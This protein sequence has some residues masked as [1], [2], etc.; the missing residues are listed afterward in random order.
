VAGKQDELIK[1]VNKMT[2]QEIIDKFEL[3]VDDAT[4]LSDAEELDLF[5]KVYQKVCSDRPWQGLRKTATGTLSTTNPYVSLPTDF[6]YFADNNTYADNQMA[7]DDNMTP[8]V[9]YVIKNGSYCPYQI[10]NIANRRKYVNTDGYCYADIPNSR[11]YFT[12]Q[13]GTAY[14]Y[15]FDYICFPATLTVA[16]TPSLIPARFHDIFVHLMAVD[17]AIIQQFPKAESY[18]AENQSRA[19]DIL[20]DLAY[21]NSQLNT[22]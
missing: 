6:G 9:V 5:N 12:L 15:E 8:N 7:I 18:A 17:H 22:Q 2:V 20:A 21:Y 19:N 16:D 11:L 13:P 4:E 14:N 3:Y 10:I 1:R